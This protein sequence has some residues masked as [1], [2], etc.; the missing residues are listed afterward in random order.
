MKKMTAIMLGLLILA[1]AAFTGE[2]KPVKV[3]DD[4]KYI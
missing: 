1:S 2:K 3:I 4:H